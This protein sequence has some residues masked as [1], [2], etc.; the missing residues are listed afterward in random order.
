V[1]LDGRFVRVNRAL[2]EM[3]GYSSDEL[4]GLTFQAITHPDDL[5]LDRA[6]AGQLVVERLRDTS[7]GSVT[8]AR[9]GR[10]LMSRS[11]FQS[12]VIIREPH[13]TSSLKSKTSRSAAKS[14]PNNLGEQLL[15]VVVSCAHCCAHLAEESEQ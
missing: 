9:M 15:P 14:L 4:I 2:C 3:V 12:F 1:A 6:A 5:Q 8:S 13:F 7:A 11:A 10:S